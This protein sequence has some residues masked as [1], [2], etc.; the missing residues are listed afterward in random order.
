MLSP[1]G[2]SAL[3]SANVGQG[4]NQLND[5][6]ADEKGLNAITELGGERT[7]PDVVCQT[8]GQHKT[9]LGSCARPWVVRDCIHGSLIKR[10]H[11]LGKGD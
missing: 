5:G 4:T 6:C 10:A 8:G 1:A 9:D 3:A 2:S 7:D 11:P